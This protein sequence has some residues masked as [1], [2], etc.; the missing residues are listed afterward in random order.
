MTGVGPLGASSR[1][2]YPAQPLINAGAI[3]VTDL[4]LSGHQPR[5]ALVFAYRVGLPG[6]SG[7]GGG[8]LAVAPGKASIAP[9]SPARRWCDREATAQENQPSL[10]W[11]APRAST[12]ALYFREVASV[13]VEL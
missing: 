7:V 8:I 4:I 6:K 11:T 1:A 13:G 12:A 9:W 3:V 2:R 10:G 5:E